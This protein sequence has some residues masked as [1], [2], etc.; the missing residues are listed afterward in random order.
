MLKHLLI[1]PIRTELGELRAEKALEFLSCQ[2]IGES[3]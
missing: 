1:L 2:G 3:N